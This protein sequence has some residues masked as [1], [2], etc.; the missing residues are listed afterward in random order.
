MTA[1]MLRLRGV[2]ADRGGRAVLRD[3][4]LDVGEGASISLVGPSGSGKSTL[5]AI[6]A[7][8]ERPDQGEAER[9]ITS[10]D[11]GLVLQGHGLVS[12]LTAAEN[13][14]LPLQA[15]GRQR[16]AKRE[17]EQR[18][19]ALLDRF[20]LREAAG[21]LVETLSGGQQQRLAIARALI[22]R[23]RLVLADEPTAALDAVNARLVAELLTS[24]PSSGTA[25]V[26]ATHDSALA[27]RAAT[28]LRLVDGRLA[29]A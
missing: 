18:V 12:L 7:G 19:A 5:V 28:S 29:P 13:V 15:P 6:L 8:L 26:V 20:G 21:H 27:A 24:L 10:G 9:A 2:G 22:T 16:V 25:V 17:V 23:P 4:D 3:I 1:P 14:A 11:I